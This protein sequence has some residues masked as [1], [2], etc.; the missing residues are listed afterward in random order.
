MQTNITV[1][2]L[3]SMKHWQSPLIKSLMKKMK[4]LLQSAALG[5]PNS[6]RLSRAAL[7]AV[8]VV[9]IA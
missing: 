7:V 6:K 3:A 2:V 1:R 8:E 9:V 5:A 4:R